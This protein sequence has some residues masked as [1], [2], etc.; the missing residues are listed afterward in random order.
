MMR[1]NDP[2]IRQTLN[3]IS[4][5]IESANESAQ[6]GFYRFSQQYLAPCFASIGN[7]LAECTAPCLPNREAQL[8][9]RRRGR[10]ELNFDFYDDWDNE[11]ANEGILGWGNDELDRLLA[12]SGSVRGGGGAQQPR[13]Q[14][15]MSYGAARTRRKSSILPDQRDD[16]TVIPKSS[17]IGF[18]ER[19]PW[20]IGPRG[21]KYRPSAADLQERPGRLPH[22]DDYIQP[23]SSEAQPLIEEEDEEDAENPTGTVRKGKRQKR[24]RSTTQSSQETSNSLSSRG[25][26]IFDDEDEDAVPLDDEFAVVLARRN[27]GLASDEHLAAS[28]G[29]PRRT[30]S[31]QSSR[32]GKARELKES[33]IEIDAVRTSEIT[34]M[35]ELSKEE[36]EAEEEE[37]LEI[38]RRRSAAHQLAINQGLA[39]N[40]TPHA[41]PTSD[42]SSSNSPETRRSNPASI[43]ED[44]K[45]TE[46][47]PS[48]PVTPTS[49]RSI[50]PL[51]AKDDEVGIDADQEDAGE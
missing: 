7:C 11:S 12:G 26:L 34:S 51:S 40:R 2:R 44:D 29:R 35:A 19:L 14:R 46:P 47:F 36:Q 30:P 27:T 37:E 24:N 28:G 23:E 20:K 5:N 38:V 32:S 18:F 50:T 39:R 22:D 8:R 1:T 3:Q 25:D 43:Q 41:A 42:F 6:E 13:R 9:R 33:R 4:H 10:A 16:P 17:F 49:Q 15:K 31:G 48:Y 45:P 21:V